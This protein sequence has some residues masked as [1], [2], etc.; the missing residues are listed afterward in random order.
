VVGRFWNELEEQHTWKIS[1]DEL[2]NASVELG[3][4]PLHNFY[5]NP[6]LSGSDLK[7]WVMDVFYY[8][9]KYVEVIRQMRDNYNSQYK[10][11]TT[12]SIN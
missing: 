10:S 4:S 6:S 7:K 8:P 2:N 12:A 9:S 5:G 1:V 11:T 3:L